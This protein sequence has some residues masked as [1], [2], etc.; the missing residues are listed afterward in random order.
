MEFHNNLIIGGGPAGIQMAYFLKKR[1]ES[2][3]VL[4]RDD[5]AGNFFA[6]Q[7]RHRKLLS[8]NKKHTGYS[9]RGSQLRFDWNSLLDDDGTLKA[10]DYSD[11]YFPNPDIIVDYSNDYV[12]KHGLNISYNTTVKKVSKS[13]DVFTVE[14]T[15]GKELQCERLFV[16]TGLFKENIPAIKGIEH[17]DT[18][19]SASINPKDYTDKRVLILGKGNS[20]FE[21]ADNLIE[22]TEK[23][24]ICGS[25]HV[26]LA[27]GSHYVGDLRAVNNN[28]VDTYLLKSQNNIL[29]GD[30]REV[31]KEGDELIAS[32]YFESRKRSYEFPFDKIIFC[33]GFKFDDAIFDDSCKPDLTECGRLPMMTSSWESKTTKNLHFIGT[34]MQM[35]DRKKT[36]SGFIHGFRHN[37]EALDQIIDPQHT[38]REQADLKLDPMALTGHIMKR[39]SHTPAMFL[40]PGFLCDLFWL[41]KEK[42]TIKFWHDVPRDYARDHGFIDNAFTVSLEYKECDE[43]Q[44]PLTMP[45]G[46]GVAEDFYLHPIIR[47]FKEGKCVNTYF[48]PDDLDNDWFILPDHLELMKKISSSIFESVSVKQVEVT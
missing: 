12:E 9:E 14:T 32:I 18:Y 37:I 44:N 30:L 21:T 4:E 25:K 22:T 16:G 15:D 13:G 36:M 10:S 28:F 47:E 5:K 40:Q 2:Y 46:V 26:K 24:T 19:N 48:L 38:W 23:I 8:I 35:R 33:T 34:I 39:I 29:D 42:N 41:D 31:R 3:C 1:N 43:N 7:P 17:C 20:G 11:E 45:R 27:W 6:T